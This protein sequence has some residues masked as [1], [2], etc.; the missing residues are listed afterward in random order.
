MYAA[1]IS[2]VWSVQL[3]DLFAFYIQDYMQDL[4]SFYIFVI[5]WEYITHAS[6][7]LL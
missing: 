3:Q 2:S 7:R 4:F 5:F 1:V 6:V